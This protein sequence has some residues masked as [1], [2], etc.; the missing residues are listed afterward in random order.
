[1]F[2]HFWG[3]P[4]LGWVHSGS[5]MVGTSEARFDSLG[6]PRSPVSQV[7]RRCRRRLFSLP[8]S[9]FSALRHAASAFWPPKITFFSRQ[10]MVYICFILYLIFLT[11][12]NLGTNSW[13]QLTQTGSKKLVDFTGF[14]FDK[15]YTLKLLCR[16]I[17]EQPLSQIK[18]IY[19]FMSLSQ[20]QWCS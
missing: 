17:F 15:R 8:K 3:R 4:F 20:T 2:F 18:N 6:A 12:G 9:V 19:C 16:Y 14:D 10:V 5:L 1:M 11:E 7:A 13:V